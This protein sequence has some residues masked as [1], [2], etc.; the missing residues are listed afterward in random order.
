[1]RRFKVTG[2][3]Y[4]QLPLGDFRSA[5]HCH[6]MTCLATEN[7][8]LIKANRGTHGKIVVLAVAVSMIFVAA[9]SAF[10]ITKPDAGARAHGPVVK[11]KTTVSVARG[12]TA[13]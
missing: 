5:R 3:P 7:H 6:L 1:M 9:V 2:K 12:D 13:R 10:S 8:S 4:F 11:A